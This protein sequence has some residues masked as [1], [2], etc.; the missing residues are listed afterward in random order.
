MATWSPGGQ[1][2][3][4][5]KERAGHAWSGSDGYEARTVSSGGSKLVIFVAPRLTIMKLLVAR[6]VTAPVGAC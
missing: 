2:D 6:G 4:C 1:L 5:V 3:W